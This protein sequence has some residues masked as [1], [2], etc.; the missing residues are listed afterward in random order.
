MKRTI[1]SLALVMVSIVSYATVNISL[2]SY[3]VIPNTGSNT[4]AVLT[5]AIKKALS[6][7]TNGE[8]VV[9]T[10][11]SG[12]YDFYPH[13]DMIR[14]YFISNHEQINPKMVGLELSHIK[15]I[16]L[17]GDNVEFMM[18]GR[19][20]PLAL[21]DVVNCTIEGINIDFDRPQI[22]QVTILENDTTEGRISYTPAPWVDYEVRDGKFVT[23][24]LGWEIIPCVGMA[25]E[26][27]TRHIV[28]NTADINIGVHDV[29]EVRPGVISAP[30]KDARLKPGTVVAFRDYGRPCPG[31]FI[32]D[33]Y[34]VSIRNVKVHYAEGMALV[35]QMTENIT[36]DGFGVCLRGENDPRYFTTQ[37]D[38]THFSGCKGVI[39]STN[40]LYEGMMDDAINVHGTY[41]KIRSR[42]DSCTFIGEYMHPQT[43]G[44][45]WGS[46]G[47]SV[48][49][50]TSRTM[51]IACPPA[52]ISS[53]EPV[54]E[55]YSNLPSVEGV[56]MFKVSFTTPIDNVIDP[57][58]ATF[59]ME[60]LEWTP[61][62]YF[63]D[64][65]VR[66]NRARGALFSTPKRVV[67]ERNLFD[68]TSGTAFLLCGD[69]NGWFET[70]ACRDVTIRDNTFINALTSLYQFTNAV[71]S[72]YPE[73]PDL[74][75]QK[76]YFHSGIVIENNHFVTFD[77]PL[78]Y[79]KSVDGLKFK[80][81]KVTRNQSYPA[82]HHN[83][84]SVLL[85]HVTNSNIQQL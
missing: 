48:N 10:L 25:F 18:H 28:Y 80:G 43:Y 41:L 45:A 42:V 58:V 81:N 15:N 20:L 7:V 40:G 27:D 82:F 8:N 39:K 61:E 12:R 55:N 21:I 79:A 24:G 52:V 23:K 30:W 63:A 37:A 36:L 33:S 53:I 51:E 22:S 85:E 11:E 17:R 9:L 64:N 3:G 71:I 59:G 35:A 16:T 29:V 50:I 73:I 65:V 26:A 1:L 76:Q 67:A 70:G 68:H 54:D 56:K 66:N 62:V 46:P 6:S 78:L 19:M 83:R 5:E 75:S 49:F 38:A 69:C 47:D 72:I 34:N 13:K 74:K 77:N 2:S 14:R 84:Q 4:T 32:D 57:T 44:F 31:I 60:N